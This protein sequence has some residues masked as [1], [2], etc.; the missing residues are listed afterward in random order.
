VI[1]K[2]VTLTGANRRA[3]KSA[4]IKFTT[5]LEQSTAEMSELDTLF[6]Q[7]CVIAIKES[8][9]PFL[10]SE[11]KDLD[12]LKVDLY[13]SSKSQSKRIR[14]VLWKNQE[15]ELKRK[16][17]DEEFREY[18]RIKTEAIIEHFKSKLYD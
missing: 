7:E 12:S 1:I 16:P 8:E 5:A 17:T 6:Q 15:Y 14:N 2:L 10:D 11:L 4:S 3:D 18:Y 9:T 13:D